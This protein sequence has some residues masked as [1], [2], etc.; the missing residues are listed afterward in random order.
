M[1]YL[2]G[3]GAAASSCPNFSFEVPA[4]QSAADLGSVSAADLGSVCINILISG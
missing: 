3:E 2:S 1:D 4:A